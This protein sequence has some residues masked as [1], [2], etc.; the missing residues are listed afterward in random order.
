MIVRVLMDVSYHSPNAKE[1]LVW[2]PFLP[3]LQA[4]ASWQDFCDGGHATPV[5]VPGGA[6]ATVT[7]L[8]AFRSSCHRIGTYLSFGFD[9]TVT[10]PGGHFGTVF[11]L[12]LADPAE[13]VF[14]QVTDMATSQT[15]ISGVLSQPKQA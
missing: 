14:V 10:W 12:T 9:T 7:R 15:L 5:R 1:S 4:G 13:P 2:P 8:V 6:E 11:P 3:R